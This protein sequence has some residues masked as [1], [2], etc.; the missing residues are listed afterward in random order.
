MEPHVRVS[1]DGAPWQRIF[2][3]DFYPALGTLTE[4]IKDR[5]VAMRGLRCQLVLYILGSNLEP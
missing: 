4:A 2:L 5:W 1:I 3:F